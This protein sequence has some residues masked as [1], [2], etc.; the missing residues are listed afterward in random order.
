MSLTANVYF[1]RVC[2]NYLAELTAHA[3]TSLETFIP[4]PLEIDGGEL[5]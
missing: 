3:G 4:P 5:G 2:N 1:K